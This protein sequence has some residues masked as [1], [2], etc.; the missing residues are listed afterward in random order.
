MH[1]RID[2][3]LSID[4]ALEMEGVSGH[5]GGSPVGGRRCAPVRGRAPMG[6]TAEDDPAWVPGWAQVHKGETPYR[7]L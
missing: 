4:E 2:G 7:E 1:L 6:C 3:G 5:A